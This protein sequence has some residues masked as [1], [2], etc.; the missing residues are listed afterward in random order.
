MRFTKDH[1]K[2]IKDV[3]EHSASQED[4]YDKRA[5]LTTLYIWSQNALKADAATVYE[6]REVQLVRKTNNMVIDNLVEIALS[7]EYGSSA[8]IN[9]ENAFFEYFSLH[10]DFDP[11]EHEY[12]LKATL[13]EA[14][15]YAIERTINKET[16]DAN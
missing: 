16:P 15:N 9:A 14:F 1:L 5:E 13:E 3:A 6:A 7:E 12:L 4:D 2:I 11:E 8:Q 10:Y